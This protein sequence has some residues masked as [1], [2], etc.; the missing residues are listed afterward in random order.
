MREWQ[1]L[2]HPK[3]CY[4]FETIEGIVFEIF[5]TTNLKPLFV[6]CKILMFV[7][8]HLFEKSDLKKLDD[9]AGSLRKTTKRSKN[10]IANLE[11]S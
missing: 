9:Q 7:P 4:K 2:V 8:H 3:E 11:K 10:I 6:L 5:D 1:K